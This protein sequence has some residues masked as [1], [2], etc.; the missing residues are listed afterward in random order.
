MSVNGGHYTASCR[1]RV[2]GRWYEFSDQLISLEDEQTVLQKEPYLLFYQKV[3]NP[4]I[5]QEDEAALQSKGHQQSASSSSPPGPFSHSGTD[6]HSLGLPLWWY[7]KWKYCSHPGPICP[8]DLVCPHGR[9]KP[10]KGRFDPQHFISLS[11]EAMD[12]L[13]DKYG[14][15]PEWEATSSLRQ[16]AG[17]GH[18]EEQEGQGLP[19][20]LIFRDYDK[21]MR[22]SLSRRLVETEPCKTC[23]QA[24]R[25]LADLQLQ[26][27][28]EVQ[29]LDAAEEKDTLTE[30]YLVDAIWLQDWK[31]YIT[32]DPREDLDSPFPSPGPIANHRLID[33]KT[34]APLPNKKKATHYRGLNSQ[35]WSYLQK[36]YGGGPEIRRTTVDLYEE[37]DSAQEEEEED[38]EEEEKDNI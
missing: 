4:A 38:G 27:R 34:K 6:S 22:R 8:H 23:D 14:P 25:A 32:S 16:E 33:S 3:Q 35:V 15:F 9:L 29:R 5:L 1:N 20:L 21:A 24:H 36:T 12:Y 7:L 11:S 19:P 31:K 28:E 30:W 2:S 17:K 18:S 37:G 10:F 26:E 13:Q